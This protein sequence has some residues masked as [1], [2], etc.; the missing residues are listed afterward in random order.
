MTEAK[1]RLIRSLE[2]ALRHA[3]DAPTYEAIFALQLAIASGDD[4]TLRKIVRAAEPS[5]RGRRRSDRVLIADGL[6]LELEQRGE[7]WAPAARWEYLLT[8]IA[9]LVKHQGM[10][11]PDRA[12]LKDLYRVLQTTTDA[13]R[14][15]RAVFRACGD[16]RADNLFNAE[17]QRRGRTVRRRILARAH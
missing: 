9:A 3:T 11:L 1:A 8:V 4:D 7:R 12:H 17:T 10:R 16:A 14:I 13:K 2:E 5:G 6:R 15:V